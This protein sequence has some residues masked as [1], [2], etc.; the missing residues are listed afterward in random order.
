MLRKWKEKERWSGRRRSEPYGEEEEEEEERQA[1]RQMSRRR[2][3]P[4]G[5]MQEEKKECRSTEVE[6]E[7]RRGRRRNSSSWILTED[8]AEGHMDRRGTRRRRSEPCGTLHI[9]LLPVS[10][11]K[12]KELLKRRTGGTSCSELG[13][14]RTAAEVR[15][16]PRGRSQ[17]TGPLDHS[18]KNQNNQNSLPCV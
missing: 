11:R 18:K 15:H 1:D 13:R 2:S 17:P 14:P 12:R 8:R 7:W 5:Q 10:N 6:E 4:Y 3:E 9:Q 16:L